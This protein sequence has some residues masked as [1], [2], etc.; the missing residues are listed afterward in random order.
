MAED[1]RSVSKH[2]EAEAHALLSSLSNSWTRCV[3]PSPGGIFRLFITRQ[4]ESRK[5]DE[6]VWSKTKR[7]YP[8][9]TKEFSNMS[10]VSESTHLSQLTTLPDI[11]RWRAQHSPLREAYTFLLD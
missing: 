4:R 5:I 11:L 7:R 1:L 6:S 3:E 10:S 8:A 2:R 9:M